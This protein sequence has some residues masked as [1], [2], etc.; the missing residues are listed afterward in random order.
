MSESQSQRA[1]SAP[2]PA[3]T[4]RGIWQGVPGHQIELDADCSP[5]KVCR[6]MKDVTFDG[7]AEEG[8]DIASAWKRTLEREGKLGGSSLG[9]LILGDQR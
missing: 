2:S 7:Y 1:E 3:S 8:G 4:L 5:T 9:D 6:N